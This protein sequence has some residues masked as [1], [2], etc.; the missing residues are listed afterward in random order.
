MHACMHAYMHTHIYGCYTRSE[1]HLSVQKWRVHGSRML[2]VRSGGSNS[3]HKSMQIILIHIIIVIVISILIVI[4][5]AIV[6][7][8]VQDRLLCAR[9]PAGPARAR[10][11]PAWPSRHPP[12]SSRSLLGYPEP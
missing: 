3:K 7:V 11:S 2:K 4:V 8:K 1:C 10:S 5:I 12:G 6:T 9:C